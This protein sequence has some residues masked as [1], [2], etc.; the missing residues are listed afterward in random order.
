MC[1]G[2]HAVL[3]HTQPVAWQSQGDQHVSLHISG[4]SENS[5]SRPNIAFILHP[6]AKSMLLV[7]S[8]LVNQCNTGKLLFWG[9]VSYSEL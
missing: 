7:K 9:G 8:S 4:C 3:E 6:G 1:C 5:M 2:T